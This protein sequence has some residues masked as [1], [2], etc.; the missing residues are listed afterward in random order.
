MDQ[1]PFGGA[2]RSPHEQLDQW[3]MNMRGRICVG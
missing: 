2:D 3:G 1:D